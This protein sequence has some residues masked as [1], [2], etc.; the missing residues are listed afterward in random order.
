[1]DIYSQEGKKEIIERFTPRTKTLK[2]ST[3]AFIF[4]GTLAVCAELL[5]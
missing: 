3:L 4:G 1:M 5:R 2:N